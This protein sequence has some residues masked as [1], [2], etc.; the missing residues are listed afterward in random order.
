MNVKK[1]C[2]VLDRHFAHTLK[3]ALVRF[4]KYWSKFQLLQN[5]VYEINLGHLCRHRLGEF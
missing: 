5:E 4:K 3:A 2:K 1:P